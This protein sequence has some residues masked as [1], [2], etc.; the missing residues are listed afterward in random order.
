MLRGDGARRAGNRDHALFERR[1]A[2]A[3]RATTQV[4][5]NDRLSEYAVYLVCSFPVLRLSVNRSLPCSSNPSHCQVD[6]NSWRTTSTANACFLLAELAFWNEI[7][8]FNIE[9][10]SISYGMVGLVVSTP[11]RG[12]RF[13]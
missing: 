11:T 1:L 2:R 12:S 3:V 9:L 5:S 6:H 13:L 4:Q 10:R 7:L 8:W